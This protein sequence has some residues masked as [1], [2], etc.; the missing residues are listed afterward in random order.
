MEFALS[1]DQLALKNG[2]ETFLESEIPLDLVRKFAADEKDVS[3]NISKG[4]NAL[5]VAGLLVPEAE[6]GL[7]LGLLEA[8]QIQEAFGFH[9][10][11]EGFAST[12][13][14][15]F[16]ISQS[17]AKPPKALLSGIID[18]S[19][20]IAT[21]L[22][23]AVSRRDG[24]GITLNG[25]LASG[26]SLMVMG[27]PNPTHILIVSESNELAIA[28]IA[29]SGVELEDLVTIDRT[30]RF[31]KLVLTNAATE[32]LPDVD[33]SDL[34][35]I[36][37]TLIAA[38][39]LGA[40]QA[41]LNQA[42]AYAKE[43]EQFGRIIGSFQAVKHMCAEM[44]AKLEPSRALVWH[45]AY[46]ADV[47]DSEAPVMACLA[48]SHL[49]DVGTFIAKTSTEVHGG[50]G[51]TDLVGLHYWYKRIGVNRQLLGSPETVRADA[52]RMQ[53]W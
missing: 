44:A 41:M 33:I 8:V 17:S 12:S 22:S 30:R 47:G 23:E 42:V 2:V 31:Q 4:L 45:A 3:T 37:R 10:A 38:D 46:A 28:S 39:T 29:T 49:S 40:A 5:G 6:G 7:G 19:V 53:G 52:A 15:S 16:A 21:A 1:E 51:F 48:K 32:K 50:M 36:G 43:R 26:M 18:G 13:I 35:R 24:A 25:N 27:P 9:V 14:A 34:I 11:P 20:R